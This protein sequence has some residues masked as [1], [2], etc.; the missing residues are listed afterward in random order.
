MRKLFILIGFFV[1]IN[2]VLSERIRLSGKTN[3]PASLIRVL[4]SE[5]LIS[6]KLLTAAQTITDFKGSFEIEFEAKFPVY[7]I[8]KAG[9]YETSLL[10][11]PG[12]NY[13]IQLIRSNPNYTS[14]Y[15][16]SP[17]E[18]TM[19][20]VNDNSIH[21]TI[22]SINLIYNTF[23]L[24]HFQSIYRLKQTKYLDSLKTVIHKQNFDTTNQFIKNYIFYKLA[25]LEPVL[26][27]MTTSQVYQKYF[28]NKAILYNNPEY[29]SL[30]KEYFSNY[31]IK[32]RTTG[33]VKFFEAVE[34]GD[35]VLQ[36]LLQSDPLIG[37]NKAFAELILLY[38]LQSIFHQKALTPYSVENRLK[39]IASNSVYKTHQKIAQNI[40]SM[41]NRFVYGAPAPAFRLRDNSD[42][43][44]NPKSEHHYV[45]L[46]FL[47][48]NCPVCEQ[49]LRDLNSVS[50]KFPGQ[51]RIISIATK[52]SFRYYVDLFQKNKF[53]WSLVNLENELEL[54]ESYNI[55]V[56]PENIILLPK[57]KIGMIAAPTQSDLLENHLRMFFSTKLKKP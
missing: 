23:I 44:I 2:P 51:L 4:I 31:F 6:G 22:E 13:T 21:H 16:A 35:A 26:K 20:S 5:D 54:L 8:I 14:F 15:D 57:A 24:E 30:F 53:Y 56:F 43:L 19:L 34:A 27:S 46:N 40:L 29:I 47:K 32:S 25:S 38:Q 3:M 10:L 33:P 39:T 45:I 52:E 49:S 55:R 41:Q 18:L 36:N 1:V 28:H 48:E 12:G 7:A 42:S 9:L 17:L 37:N 50:D 11:N